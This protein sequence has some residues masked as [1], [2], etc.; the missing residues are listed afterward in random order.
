[1]KYL[2]CIDAAVGNCSVALS[3]NGKPIDLK[4]SDQ[5]F[6]TA[7]II[8][9][10]VEDILLKNKIKLSDLS[11][12]AIT[13]G[14]GS[15]TGLRIVT[16]TAKGLCYGL[17]IPL[18]TISTFNA[19]VEGIKTKYEKN[20][21]DFY[22]PLINSRKDEV[23]ISIFDGYNKEILSPTPYSLSSGI[24]NEL[25]SI[26]NKSIIFFGDG[27]QKIEPY[28]VDLNNSHLL[29]NFYYSAED[30]SVISYKKYTN[31]EFSDLAYFEPN[32]LK[33]AFTTIPKRK[34]SI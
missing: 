7:E 26:S 19:M 24:P 11:A 14:P 6:K 12:I 33:P 27:V 17:Q 4:I 10:L 34:S 32:Y 21:F 3:G 30:I 5:K 15:Y 8:N 16:S 29:K 18:I 1:M 28:T 13:E 22:V 25:I 23:Y 20:N 9:L 31:Q 2:L